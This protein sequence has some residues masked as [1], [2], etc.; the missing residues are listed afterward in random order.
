MNIDEHKQ[1]L[2]KRIKD[3]DA[4]DK[5]GRKNDWWLFPV[6]VISI[7]VG[8]YFGSWVAWLITIV[9]F[10]WGEHEQ[11]FAEFYERMDSKIRLDEL[12]KLEPS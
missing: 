1:Y 6:C 5:K 2:Q 9:S 11:S 10:L 4:K 7:C 8:V 12:K 3:I